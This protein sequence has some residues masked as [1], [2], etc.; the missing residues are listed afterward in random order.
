MPGAPTPG[1]KFPNR[2]QAKARS[3][4][5]PSAGDRRLQGRPGNGVQRSFGERRSIF[6]TASA[7]FAATSVEFPSCSIISRD[8]RH[9]V[10]ESPP[11]IVGAEIIVAV[12]QTDAALIEPR[13]HLRRIF[14]IRL[15]GKPKKWIR[16]DAIKAG[17]YAGERGLIIHAIDAVRSG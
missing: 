15:R 13:N 8:G 4:P 2:I 5:S 14:C 9:I 7:R 12:R 16:S 1:K 11:I 3:A 6:I 17:D 10:C